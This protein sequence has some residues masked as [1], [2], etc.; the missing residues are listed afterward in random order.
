MRATAELMRKSKELMR[1]CGYAEEEP[2]A[3]M[4]VYGYAV[5]AL[6]VDAGDAGDAVD[7]VDAL[8]SLVGVPWRRTR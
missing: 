6:L 7:A 5:D 8:V 4:P 1:L 2:Y 3:S